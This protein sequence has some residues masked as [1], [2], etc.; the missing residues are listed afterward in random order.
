M[1]RHDVFN[2]D[3]CFLTGTA[4]ELIPVVECDGRVDRHRPARAD[5][6]RAPPAVSGA[7]PRGAM[8]ERRDVIE[9][10]SILAPDRLQRPLRAGR[11]LCLP[12]GRAPGLG[13]APAARPLRDPAGRSRP[14]LD[15]G[16]AAAVLQ[17]ERRSGPGDARPLCSTRPG[18]SPRSVVTAVRWGSPVE[19]IVSYAV[20]H[21]IDLIIIATHG[22]TGLS[23]VLLG[24]VAERIVREAP[25]PVLTIRDRIAD[26]PRLARLNPAGCSESSRTAMTSSPSPSRLI[27]RAVRS[28]AALIYRGRRS[29]WPC[30]RCALADGTIAEREVVLHRGAVAL[31]PMVDDEHVC[32]VQNRRYAV[33]KTLL[34]VPAGTIDPGESP[35]Q[36]AERE[37]QE[38]TGYRAGP[39]PPRPRVVRQPG[40]DDRADVPLSLRGPPAGP[41]RA[42]SSMSGSRP[43]IVPWER[44]ARHGRRRPDRGRQDHCSP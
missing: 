29:T 35:E 20:D 8:N 11:P 3:E 7:G 33:G 5:H 40:R 24:S 6:P 30:S 43:S 16:H 39:H 9:I 31:V 34:E 15:A 25:C 12:A 27:D 28:I 38:E 22:R 19:S 42:P 17:G 14:A 21:R 18:A 13:A 4:A 44:G 32:L 1:D 36:T 23:H 26:R 41:V 37:L 2:A 10:K